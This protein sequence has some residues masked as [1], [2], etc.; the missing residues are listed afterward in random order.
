M[1]DIYQEYVQA[2]I[3]EATHIPLNMIFQDTGEPGKMAGVFQFKFDPK[4]IQKLLA[5]GMDGKNCHALVIGDAFVRT[6][7]VAISS[8]LQGVGITGIYMDGFNLDQWTQNG[9]ILKMK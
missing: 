8:H 4:V 6:K 2:A 5:G 9:K 1:K 3:G 7:I